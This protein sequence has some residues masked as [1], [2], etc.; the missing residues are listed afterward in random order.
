[1]V[2]TP[3]DVDGT[4]ATL[5][6]SYSDVSADVTPQA[7]SDCEA[8]L[9]SE[10][11]GLE[12]ILSA[13]FGL[14]TGYELPW[15]WSTESL[16]LTA[17][18]PQGWETFDDVELPSPREYDV[19]EAARDQRITLLARKYEGRSLD[20]EEKARLKILTE[21]LRRLVPRVTPEDWEE[22]TELAEIAVGFDERHQAI[23][24]RLGFDR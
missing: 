20:V 11:I 22:L 5:K 24:R 12:N 4:S 17:S 7:A 13:T 15:S 10:R 18:I 23:R 19:M 14:S 2:M 8:S 3:V 9:E 16:S 1:M 21:R 6:D